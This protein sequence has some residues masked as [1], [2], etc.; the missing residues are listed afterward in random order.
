MRRA[1]GVAEG[2]HLI[3]EFLVELDVVVHRVHGVPVDQFNLE[4]MHSPGGVDIGPEDVG[5][6]RV[7]G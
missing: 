7:T 1:G 3:L 4:A 2:N 5:A 6:D